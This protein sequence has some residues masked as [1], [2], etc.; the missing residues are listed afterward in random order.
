[1]IIDKL[2]FG[3]L[4]PYPQIYYTNLATHPPATGKQFFVRWQC[5]AFHMYE[6]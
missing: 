2:A 1:M 5:G 3:I 6:T 4:L